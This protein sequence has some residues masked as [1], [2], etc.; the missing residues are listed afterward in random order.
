MVLC[1]G[2]ATFSS[3]QGTAAKSKRTASY[4][5]SRSV[6]HN[7][8]RLSQLLTVL[9]SLGFAFLLFPF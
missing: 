9:R 3:L 4:G 7:R 8:G 1:S 2:C 6:V 5:R